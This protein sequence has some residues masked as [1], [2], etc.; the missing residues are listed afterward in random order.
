MFIVTPPLSGS[1]NGIP[2]L[3]KLL[4]RNLPESLTRRREDGIADCM[5]D[6]WNCRF[7]TT[8]DIFIAVDD[9]IVD[10]RIDRHGNPSSESLQ[11]YENKESQSIP[12]LL[13][14][15]GFCYQSEQHFPILH[16]SAFGW[17]FFSLRL[18]AV[19]NEPTH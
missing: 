15:W 17:S 13:I 8:A 1:R 6:G 9:S 19:L 11:Q 18:L 5:C 3:L 12:L 2:N 7:S 14:F 16:L 4:N 10:C